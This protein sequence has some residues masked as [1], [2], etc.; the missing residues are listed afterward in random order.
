MKQTQT[1]PAHS[2]KAGPIQLKGHKLVGGKVRGIAIV[3]ADS[4][5]FW[6]G[7]DFNTGIVNERGHNIEGQSVAGKILVCPSGKGSGA[8]STR[9][10][11]MSL[12]KVAPIAIVNSKADVVMVI[13]AI[14]SKI[15]MV[16]NFDVDPVSVIHTGDMVEVDA[17]NGVVTIYP[18]GESIV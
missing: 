2:G 17:D 12:R 7:V 4:L 1:N 9:L 10:Y 18:K 16:D 6:G 8:S 15:P 11:D 14:I 13:G 3:S 5:S